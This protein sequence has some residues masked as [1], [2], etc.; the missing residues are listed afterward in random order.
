MRVLTINPN[1]IS[2]P[3]DLLDPLSEALD[4]SGPAVEIQPAGSAISDSPYVDVLPEDTALIVP[5]SGSTGA[6][7]KVV[8]SR[9]ALIASGRAT[10]V[11]LDGP[12]HWLLPLSV[13]HIAG[14]QVLIRSVLAGTS[15]TT[16]DTSIPFDAEG[17]AEAV[18]RMPAAPTPRYT[19]L[20]PTQLA[21]LLHETD[22]GCSA[23]I[24][25]ARSFEAILVGGAALSPRLA[26]EAAAAGLR[27]V[28]TYG[29]SETCGGCVYD[30][31]PL[32]GVQARTDAAGRLSLGGEVVASGY[33]LADANGS[34]GVSSAE[35]ARLG[36]QS[37]STDRAGTR[38]F[39]TS[40]MGTVHDSRVTVQ[41]RAD[42]VIISGGINV[43][44][45]AVEDVIGS[46]PGVAEVLVTSV[47][48]DE[49]GQKVVALLCTD[50]HLPPISLAAVRDRVGQTLGR[51][52]APREII[53]V[54]AIPLRGLG[55]PDRVAARDLAVDY[56]RVR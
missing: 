18:A 3:L 32:D 20:V 8:L 27:L 52:S 26:E 36:Q 25:A 47:P 24:R 11:R 49:W 41:G 14:L 29:M 9:R 34:A 45:A 33:L 37:F 19:S 38:W 54:P 40:D 12:G 7:K 44:P 10:A 1:A 43:A 51:A 23:A 28:T 2:D 48:D 39:S 46:M 16:L 30:G 56:L 35:G 6:A 31:V 22:S 53:T 13:A 21:R 55:K 42:D 5:T 17:F 4:G 15:P 50:S